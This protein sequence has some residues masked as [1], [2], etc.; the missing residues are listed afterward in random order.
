MY[1]HPPFEES[2][3]ILLTAWAVEAG[4][5]CD[6]LSLLKGLDYGSWLQGILVS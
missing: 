4:P 3:S 6:T 2:T 5:A 1:S